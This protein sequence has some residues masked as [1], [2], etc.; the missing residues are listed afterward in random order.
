MSAWVQ[1][2]FSDYDMP[3]GRTPESFAYMIESI[4]SGRVVDTY[5]T[6]EKLGAERMVRGELDQMYDV[7][8]THDGSVKTFAADG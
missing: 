4:W 2:V 1:K 5:W 8:L 6:D 7:R 3:A